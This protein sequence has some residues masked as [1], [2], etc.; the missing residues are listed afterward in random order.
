MKRRLLALML[1]MILAVS[2]FPAVALADAYHVIYDA[3]NATGGDVPSGPVSVEEGSMVTVLGNSG[4]LER[5]GYIFSGWNTSADGN[6]TTY[7]E[8]DEFKMPGS[9]VTLY[10]KWTA[11]NYHVT[12][13]GNGAQSGSAP[14][15]TNGYNI[16]G[17]VTVLG[18][19]GG[20]ALWGYAFAGWNTQRDGSGTPY[21]AGAKFNIGSADVTLY[22]QWSPTS[23]LDYAEHDVKKIQ[24]FLNQDSWQRG[25]TNCQMLGYDINDPG[26]WS[27]VRWTTAGG[28]KYAETILW[29]NEMLAGTLDLTGCS[30]LVTLSCN[31]N[32]IT[33]LKL[34]GLS[35]LWQL[36][37]SGN[38][39]WYQSAALDIAGDSALTKLDCSMCG[40]ES[41]DLSGLVSL[42]TLDCSDNFLSEIG[43]LDDPAA[44]KKLD[45][46]DNIFES[47][48]VSGLLALRHLDCSMNQITDL[49][50]GNLANLY[51]LNCSVN[52][53][54]S[55]ENGLDVSGLSSLEHLDC[56]SNQLE[57]VT[58]L[59]SL[60]SLEEL[61][62]SNNR[63]SG[64][65]DAR[66]FAGL[67]LL[68][69]SLNEITGMNV[70]GLT[71]LE[72]L[73]CYGNGI[74]SLNI[75]NLP[76][77]EVIDCSCNSMR[78]LG[79]S[80]C[81]A[82]CYVDCSYNS[83]ITLDLSGFTN[84]D[85]LDCSSNS[86]T[87]LNLKQNNKLTTLICCGNN[88]TDLD[89]SACENLNNLNCSAKH[90]VAKIKGA[91]VNLLTAGNGSGSI[92]LALIDYGRYSDDDDEDSTYIAATAVPDSLMIF[93]KWTDNL[94]NGSLFSRNPNIFLEPGENYSLTANFSHQPPSAK[95]SSLVVEGKYLRFSKNVYKYR[96]K[97]YEYEDSIV[98]FPTAENSLAVITV[99]GTNLLTDEDGY[100]YAV[101]SVPNGATETVRIKV[102]YNLYLTKTYTLTV[103]RAK[104][105][106]CYLK[107][108]TADNG[109][110]NTGFDPELTNYRLE[111]GENTRTV[112]IIPST[113]SPLA[114]VTPAAGTYTLKNGE[115]KTVKFVVK[116]QSGKKKTYTVRI[117]RAPS[118][119]AKLQ[120]IKTKPEADG[121]AFDPQVK[122]Y[123]VTMPAGV[124]SLTI[125][126]KAADSA[127]TVK[128]GAKKTTAITVKPALGGYVDVT[129]CVWPQDKTVAAPNEYHIRVIRTQ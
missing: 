20:L 78:S 105:S 10:A 1:S 83:L 37:C 36:D 90:I 99:N 81:A 119:N 38:G 33:A 122:D 121:V 113:D 98:I 34:S 68:N 87:A 116:A 6:G 127:A 71:K 69:C 42:S 32:C 49:R 3:N 126:V 79:F 110:F 4:M 109:T 25:K 14:E 102:T 96:L 100:R 62:V 82:L 5:T 8:N 112:K 64:N 47:L 7:V 108:L 128:I 107:S 89:I 9:D 117:H 30:H 28:L 54:D 50:L 86:L 84:L 75:N 35:S 41:L 55:D 26:T 45:C 104:S 56:S 2:M 97:M 124:S 120:Y 52:E 72:E 15:D 60:A 66:A 16:G 77:L 31:N 53:L 95:L 101:I 73:Y 111:L 51:Y 23:L 46:Y 58:G 94:K 92:E 57:S 17:E 118:T 74:G 43:H 93:D 115:T 39:S 88:F 129:V 63:I 40:L 123:T 13:D 61:D 18:N 91:N 80:G 27:D 11:L 125:S 12:Y 67:I 76:A 70:T 22:A 48:D 44:L 85:Y 19:T 65:F 29:N 24:A 21:A 114:K 103:S 106:N 59:S